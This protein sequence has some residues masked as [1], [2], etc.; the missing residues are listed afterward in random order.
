MFGAVGQEL[1]KEPGRDRAEGLSV[2][3]AE[4]VQPMQIQAEGGMRLEQ[5]KGYGRFFGGVILISPMDGVVMNAKELE[6]YFEATPEKGGGNQAK[7]S[8]EEKP[9]GVEVKQEKGAA[10][11]LRQVIATG[12]VAI[13]Q[14]RKRPDG[15]LERSVAKARRAVYEAST[16]NVTL[17]GWPQVKNG[18]NVVSALT[19]ETVIVMNEKGVLDVQGKAKGSFVRDAAALKRAERTGVNEGKAQ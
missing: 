9:K 10:D 8:G 16:G 7:G 11:G 1:A 3:A 19:E 13:V 18:D 12:E 6:V 14:E 4:E 2:A 17:T 5:A 15:V